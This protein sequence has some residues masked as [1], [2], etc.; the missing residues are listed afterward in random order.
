MTVICGGTNQTIVGGNITDDTR[1][2]IHPSKRATSGI[3]SLRDN[4]KIAIGKRFYANPNV[5]IYIG[6]HQT[7]GIAYN[8]AYPGI[9]A[10]PS[11]GT[12][13]LY[14]AIIPLRAMNHIISVGKF[15]YYANF[16]RCISAN[17]AIGTVDNSPY[18]RFAKPKG[19][20]TRIL[21]GAIIPKRRSN[22]IITISKN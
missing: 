13:I 9:T 4:H 22:H 8:S 16:V 17:Q 7:V 2:A 1:F 3:P 6:A 12:G 11:N 5:V 19:S 14:G 21:C 20:C 15:C 10:A 18:A